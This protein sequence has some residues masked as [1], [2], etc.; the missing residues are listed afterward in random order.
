MQKTLDEEMLNFR[1][2]KIQTLTTTK[3]QSFDI[4]LLNIC[5]DIMI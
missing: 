3:L 2:A 5:I 4:Y 1:R